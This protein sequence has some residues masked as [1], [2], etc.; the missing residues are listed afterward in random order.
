M[1]KSEYIE[2]LMN[3]FRQYIGE[4]DVDK[5]TSKRYLYC[6]LSC[7]GYSKNRTGHFEVNFERG[8]CY[9]YR[10]VDGSSIYSVLKSL[11]N[12][13]NNEYINNLLR[14]YFDFYEYLDDKIKNKKETYKSYDFTIKNALKEKSEEIKFTDE[15]LIFLKSRFPTLSEQQIISLVKNFGFLPNYETKGF[16]YSSFFNKFIYLYLYRNGNFIKSKVNNNEVINDSKDYF[17]NVM[18]YKY[19]NLYMSEGIIDLMTISLSDPLKNS[20]SSNFLAFCS[21]NYKFIYEF[22]LS[23]GKFFYKNI[24]LIIDNDVNRQNFLKGIINTL[25]NGTNNPKFKLFQNLYLIEVPSQFVDLN[26][27]YI[28]TH[29]IKDIL[30]SKIV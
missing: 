21:R 27:L 18:S 4:F 7:Q 19:E 22:L 12:N 6:P 26:D 8:T 29:N 11:K 28:N 2:I 25:K 24:Y 13:E 15:Q 16:Y 9:C 23:S 1:T 30:I 20:S 14:V 3:L 10:C 17:Y 5:G